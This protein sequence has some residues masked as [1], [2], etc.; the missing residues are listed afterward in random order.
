[1]DVSRHASQHEIP[2]ARPVGGP[3]GARHLERLVSE[4]K[5]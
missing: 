5:S 2:D 4:A 1:M 3:F